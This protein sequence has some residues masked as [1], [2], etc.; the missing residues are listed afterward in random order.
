MQ[1]LSSLYWLTANQTATQVATRA[2]K[3]NQLKRLSI[4]A[5][6]GIGLLV[7][8]SKIHVPF[9]PVP[10]TL[11]TMLVVLIGTAYGFRLGTATMA[12]FLALGALGLPVFAGPTAGL[13]IFSGPTGGYLL[14][15]LLA[16]AACGFLADQ[17]Y[18]KTFLS[19]FSIVIIANLC[20]Y[21]PGLLVLG[22]VI[23]WDKPVL[24][25]GLYPFIYGAVLK[26][27]LAGLLVPVAWRMLKR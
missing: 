3:L 20:I 24:E 27:M 8:S 23:G 9:Y 15:F 4:L 22:A 21:I 18:G 25:Y 7:I 16:A 10:M 17:G 26:M 19:M 13:A 5:L 6:A 14:G 2:T 11:Q 12:G 1:T